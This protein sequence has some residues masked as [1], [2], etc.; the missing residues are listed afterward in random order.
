MD[1]MN[2]KPFT[3]NGP[4]IKPHAGGTSVPI[5]KGRTVYLTSHGASIWATR[6]SGYLVAAFLERYDITMVMF[7]LGDLIPPGRSVTYD[8]PNVIRWMDEKAEGEGI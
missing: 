5:L 3:Y 4:D 7:R 6:H 1:N 8:E 2:L